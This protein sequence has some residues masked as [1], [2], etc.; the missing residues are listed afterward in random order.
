MSKH[1][2]P[3]TKEGDAGT[4]L[5]RVADDLAEK[6]SD[7]SLVHPKKTAQILDP[8]IRA[9]IEKLHEDYR[10]QIEAAKAAD[11]VHKQ[12]LQR[13]KAEAEKQAA[14]EGVPKK[15]KRGA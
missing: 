1:G 15:P 7:L 10:P 14:Q 6:L 11:E 3:P 12:E 13:I 2:R 8:L 5:V 9:E 4:K